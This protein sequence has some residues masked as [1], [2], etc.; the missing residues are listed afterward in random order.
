MKLQGKVA[1]ITGAASG[2]GAATARLF[3]VQGAKLLLLDRNQELLQKLAEEIKGSAFVC[4]ITNEQQVEE[5]I[6]AEKQKIAVCVNC[7]GIAP[8]GRILSREGPMPMADFTKA[9]TVNLLGSFNV[10]RLVA[11]QM[12]REPEQGGVIINTASVAA[13]D[14]QLGQ[15]AYSASKGA[16]ASL[17]LPAARE[18]ARFGIRVVAIAPGIMNTPMMQGMPDKV[19]ESLLQQ[20]T[21]P[22]R[23]GEA[24][25]FAQ[26]ALHIVEN[27]Y[28]NGTVIRLD[29]GIRM[30]SR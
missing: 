21:Y 6:S 19:Q 13:Y 20:I 12:S 18:L 29:A 8:A 30:N 11:E 17:T 26:L 10:L 9:I 27:E 2:L 28:L 25:E 7:A 22:Q 15:A 5:I 16:I 14:G 1:L 23:F 24:E 3:A 4:D